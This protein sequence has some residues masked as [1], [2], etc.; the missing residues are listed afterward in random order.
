MSNYPPGV[1]GFEPQIA[2]YPEEEATVDVGPCA[3]ADEVNEA[4]VRCD[5]DGGEVE[6]TR[7]YY[8]RY[9]GGFLWACPSCGHEN[10]TAESYDPEGDAQERRED[11]ERD[12][13]AF[14]D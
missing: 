3:R 2:G 1:S 7:V 6:G 4:G 12:R 13:R 14:D 9:E 8:S 11:E 10:E 5:F